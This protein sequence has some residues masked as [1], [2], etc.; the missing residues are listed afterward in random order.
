MAFLSL[1]ADIHGNIRFDVVMVPIGH[2]IPFSLL[3]PAKK[4][5]EKLLIHETKLD[6]SLESVS[7]LYFLKNFI[8]H[9]TPQ[10]K[11]DLN[12]PKIR[13]YLSKLLLRIRPETLT[14]DQRGM[15]SM[16]KVSLGFPLDFSTKKTPSPP[17]KESRVLKV[18]KYVFFVM[19]GFV[20]LSVLTYSIISENDE[21]LGKI[22]DQVMHDLESRDYFLEIFQCLVGFFSVVR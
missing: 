15:L 12:H 14:H 3:E 9:L 7:T 4:K 10:K 8:L 16:V 20:F 6:K 13:D 2:E 19:V 11:K 21:V 22:Y 17:P 1:T 18:L 5:P